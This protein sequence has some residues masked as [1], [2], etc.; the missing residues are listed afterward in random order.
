MQGRSE[1]ESL[2]TD[3]LLLKL[4]NFDKRNF[5]KESLLWHIH[6][7]TNCDQNKRTEQ[8]RMALA[9]ICAYGDSSTAS[10]VM[11]LSLKLTRQR[12]CDDNVIK[13][14]T[15]VNPCNED[16]ED[17]DHGDVDHEDVL[18]LSRQHYTPSFIRINLTFKKEEAN[19]FELLISILSRYHYTSAIYND[20]NIQ[21][22]LIL[23]NTEENILNTIMEILKPRRQHQ[24]F[25]EGITKIEKAESNE[26]SK[27]YCIIVITFRNISK[28]FKIKRTISIIFNE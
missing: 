21:M 7:K 16:D 1:K 6:R 11:Q 17:D 13:T 15:V 24:F 2:E 25:D 8:K 5:I 19:T 20:N 4:P 26:E 28:R 22:H 3:N 18:E 23:K 10:N 27:L 9:N 12:S 14:K